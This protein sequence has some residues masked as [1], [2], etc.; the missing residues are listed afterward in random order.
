MPGRWFVCPLHQPESGVHPNRVKRL[1]R[2]DRPAP[3]V[4]IRR[5]ARSDWRR[6][7]VAIDTLLVVVGV[8][9]SVDD[10]KPSYDL[11]AH[12]EAGLIDAYD[13]A[14]PTRARRRSSESARP[15]RTVGGALGGG[16]GLATGSALAP[17]CRRRRRPP[18]GHHSQGARSLGAIAASAGGDEPPRP[19][20]ARREQLDDLSRRRRLRHGAEGPNGRRSGRR[21]STGRRTVSEIR[22]VRRR[23]RGLQFQRNRLDRGVLSS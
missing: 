13:R 16:I 14:H 18:S 9:G 1:R 8:Y 3:P 21:R 15:G 2:M 6:N 17:F 12:T 22:A 23:G 19:Q 7:T 11:V 10:A 20:G 4:V 5:H